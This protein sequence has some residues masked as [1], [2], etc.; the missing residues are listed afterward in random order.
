MFSLILRYHKNSRKY[1]KQNDKIV[2]PFQLR[3]F[4]DSQ[5]FFLYNAIE[6]I[7]TKQT[8]KLQEIRIIQD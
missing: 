7:H 1:G 3:V 6:L 2:G 5:A 8:Q 4:Y